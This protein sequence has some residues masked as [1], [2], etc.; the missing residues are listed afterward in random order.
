MVLGGVLAYSAWKI[1]DVPAERPDRVRGALRTPRTARGAGRGAAIRR[2]APAAA[3]APVVSRVP[4]PPVLPPITTSF[5]FA[6]VSTGDVGPEE[7]GRPGGIPGATGAG[8]AGRIGA[9]DVLSGKAPNVVA[10]RLLF[11]VQPEYP[12]AARRARRQGVVLLQAVIGTEGGVEDVRVLS[13]A[14]P[15][16]E[17]P[18]VRAVRQWR[19]APATLERRAVRVYLTVTI[20]FTLH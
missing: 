2:P 9:D 16:F 4:I 12:D 6:A 14:S 13:S 7:E 10:P 20:F 1:G 8:E 19:Y 5:D 15:L 11:Q 18:A 3:T 17:E